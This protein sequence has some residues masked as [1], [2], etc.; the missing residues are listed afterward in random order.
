MVA[1]MLSISKA[2]DTMDKWGGKQD[3]I[4]LSST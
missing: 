4:Y 3:I 2:D 1:L